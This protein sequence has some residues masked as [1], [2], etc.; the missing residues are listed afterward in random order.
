SRGFVTVWTNGRNADFF[1]PIPLPPWMFDG[2]DGSLQGVFGQVLGSSKCLAGSEVLC[3]GPDGRFEARVSWKIP[4][5][6]T[7]SG[8][9]LPL[10][11]DTGALWFFGR[12]NLELMVKIVD[13]RA[14]NERFWVFLGSLSNVEYTLT[15]TDTATGVAKSYHNPAS[16]LASLA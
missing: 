10:T 2:R 15:V 4:S 13:G 6:E 8:K 1:F 14:V 3:L 16:R 5:G 9:S 12:D 7:G 11:A